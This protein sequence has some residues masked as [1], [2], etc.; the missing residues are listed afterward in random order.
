MELGYELTL[1][2]LLVA[3][4]GHKDLVLLLVLLLL[5]PPLVV[6]LMLR[7]WHHHLLRLGSEMSLHRGRG[8]KVLSLESHLLLHRD[9]LVASCAWWSVN[10]H[11]LV[12]NLRVVVHVLLGHLVEL[13]VEAFLNWSFLSLLS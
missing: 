3:R 4:L 12:L 6:D 11:G 13:L 7:C 5:L 9:A 2:L 1:G 8:R 10:V